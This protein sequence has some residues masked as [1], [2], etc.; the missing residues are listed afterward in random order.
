MTDQEN[1][2]LVPPTHPTHQTPPI[3]SP[4]SPVRPV[5]DRL[6]INQT[7]DIN[8]I[9]TEGKASMQAGKHTN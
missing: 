6:Y 7:R 2:L 4:P 8:S 3:P 1:H 5:E 9:T